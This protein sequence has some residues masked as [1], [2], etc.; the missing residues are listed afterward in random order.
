MRRACLAAVLVLASCGGGGAE[1]D[2]ASEAGCVTDL[3]CTNW[4][5]CDGQEACVD[6]GCV[7][8]VPLACDDDDECTEDACD[9]EAGCVFAPLDGDDDGWPAGSVGGVECGGSDCDDGDAL[10]FPGAVE[11]CNGLDDDCDDVVDEDWSEIG[12]DVP[13]DRAGTYPELPAVAWTGTE[14][15]VAWYSRRGALAPAGIAFARVSAAGT[16]ALAGM[17]I[18]EDS[19]SLEAP[20]LAWSGSEFGLAFQDD[21][22]GNDEIYFARVSASGTV[23]GAEVRV[24]DDP[25]RSGDPSMVWTGSEYAVA[26]IDLRHTADEVF[27]ARLEP[28]GTRIGTD[29]RLTDMPSASTHPA[30]VWTGSQLAVA[31]Q[32]NIDTHDANHEI[33]FMRVAPDGTPAGGALRVTVDPVDSIHPSLAW[34]G[35][36][37]GLTW[38]DMRDGT[39]ELYLARI[40]AGGEK[41]GGD[42]RL[43]DAPMDTSILWPAP[44]GWTGSRYATAWTDLRD[45]NNEIYFALA[46]ADGLKLGGDVRLTDDPG[47]SYAPGMA[48]TGSL[49]LVAW[50]DGRSDE[51]EIYFTR[52]GCE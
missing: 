24:T 32:D 11:R 4:L 25:A 20:S 28:D 15:G 12:D 7:P 37:F 49:F 31:W 48:W 33:Y 36:E 50:G 34:T 9:E 35:S 10:I 14:M 2:A 3:D 43:T 19:G 16:V 1:R 51:G 5:A 23:T 22:D 17:R 18:V 46:S 13:I 6:G 40:S 8:G 44:I 26:W 39:W 38:F 41:L 42:V 29:A 52:V 47:G 21:R 30:L 27:L 45:G